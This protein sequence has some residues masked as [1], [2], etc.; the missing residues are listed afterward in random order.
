MENDKKGFTTDLDERSSDTVI[1]QPAITAGMRK[2]EDIT[3]TSHRPSLVERD[4]CIWDAIHSITSANWFIHTGNLKTRS[5]RLVGAEMTQ[6]SHEYQYC[7]G[8]FETANDNEGRLTWYCENCNTKG[9]FRWI[10]RP[11]VPNIL[12]HLLLKQA[13]PSLRTGNYIWTEETGVVSL[14]HEALLYKP[15]SQGETPPSWIANLGFVFMPGMHTLESLNGFEEWLRYLVKIKFDQLMEMHQ[16][17]L[18]GI[19][20]PKHLG[21]LNGRTRFWRD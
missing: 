5:A 10:K 14:L 9:R 17:L 4:R 19:V 1:L 16:S 13:V 6:E 15:D 21:T 8:L 2:F 3:R 18:P 20:G 12:L 11:E 7:G